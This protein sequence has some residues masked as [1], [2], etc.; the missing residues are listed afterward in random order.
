MIRSATERKFRLRALRVNASALQFQF[1]PRARLR[2][3]TWRSV[4]ANGFA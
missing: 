3:V 4:A 1:A 2:A